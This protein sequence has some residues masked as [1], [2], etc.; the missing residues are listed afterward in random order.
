MPYISKED[1]LK[2]KRIIPRN[3]LNGLEPVNTIDIISLIV[4]TIQE[5]PDD[6]KEGYANYVIS[7]IVTEGLKPKS[8]WR[9]FA[10]N[11]ALGV[12]SAAALE[13][14]RRVVVKYEDECIKSNGDLDC[15]GD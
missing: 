1:K 11:R 5:T 8:G 12:F 2:F 3:N 15:Y 14:Y 13:F 10:I 9:Y 6:K 7:R 4:S